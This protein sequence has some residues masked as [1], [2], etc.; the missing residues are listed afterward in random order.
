M[1]DFEAEVLSRF[2]SDNQVQESLMLSSRSFNHFLF[3]VE[4]YGLIVRMNVVLRQGRQ[5][6]VSLFYCMFGVRLSFPLNFVF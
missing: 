2:Y 3:H 4:R 1:E 5:T 6:I